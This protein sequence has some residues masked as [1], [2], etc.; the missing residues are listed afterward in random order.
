MKFFTKDWYL[1]ECEYSEKLD[2]YWKLFELNEKHLPKWYNRDFS[3]H[4]EQIVNTEII[5]LNNNV[6]KLVLYI[7]CC[8]EYNEVQYLEF[9]N[10]TI[11]ENCP[12]I[13]SYCIADEVYV[14][15]N[16]MFE[17]HLLLQNFQN[18]N[19]DNLFYFTIS[20]EKMRCKTKN[21]SLC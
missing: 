1:N 19:D 15:E 11:I 10:F 16:G 20:C 4:D 12:L 7:D 21:S 17:F 3:L 9:E 5:T 6:K 2:E 8:D 18:E 14:K 13:H